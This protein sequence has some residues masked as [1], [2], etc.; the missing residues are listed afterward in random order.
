MAQHTSSTDSKDNPQAIKAPAGSARPEY[1]QY[2]VNQATSI[3]KRAG[4]PMPDQ[5]QKAKQ[6]EQGSDEGPG[7]SGAQAGYGNSRTEHGK[8]E[9]DM[10]DPKEGTDAK[11]AKGDDERAIPGETSTS[12]TQRLQA[13]ANPELYEPD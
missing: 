7:S 9:R 3:N 6:G 10:A 8:E 5:Q 2:E 1:D 11:K 12:P 4:E 13:D